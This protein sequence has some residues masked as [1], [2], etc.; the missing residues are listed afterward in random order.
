MSAE[1]WYEKS[2]RGEA[3]GK[4]RV[5]PVALCLLLSLLIH[6][7]MAGA[8]PYALHIMVSP[9][10]AQK[11]QEQRPRQHALQIVRSKPQPTEF[12]K[13]DP[14]QP[15]QMPE[16]PDFI[17]KRNT[18]ESASEFAPD[19]YDDAPL[20]TQNGE[21]NAPEIVT[22]DQTQ[23]DGDLAHDGVTPSGSTASESS[24]SISPDPASSPEAE[25][26]EDEEAPPAEGTATV[27]PIPTDD[28]IG[29]LLLQQTPELQEETHSPIK[30][31]MAVK[32]TTSRNSAVSQNFYDPSLA[33]HMQTQRGFRTYERR[34]RSTGRF[35]IG[36]K[37]SL[38][39][40]ATPLGRYEEEIY[41]RIAYFWHLACDEHRGDI[42]PGSV[43]ISLRLNT[44]GQLVNMD[45]VRRQGASVTQQAF[46]FGAIRRASLP[47]MPPHVQQEL[48]GDL[49]ELIFQFN[50]D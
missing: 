47:P 21:E 26:T 4:T 10:V 24:T 31:E 40:A 7:G 19:R 42:I 9:Q 15:E 13:T 14:D 27:N 34:T 36:R 1:K 32:P 35:V 43:V 2:M 28:D 23:Q 8:L 18:S 12:V 17:G 3:T 39:V 41:R 37:P 22:F 11:P 25:H 33:E 30:I 49:L 44:R 48:V 50:F 46:T 20:P 38:N 29:T 16:E 45:L 5:A 6:G